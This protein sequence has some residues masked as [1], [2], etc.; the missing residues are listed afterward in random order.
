MMRPHGILD[1]G[2]SIVGIVHSDIP[3]AVAR[4][5][6]SC[7][8]RRGGWIGAGKVDGVRMSRGVD[9]RKSGAMI[10][11]V[12]VAIGRR[13]GSRRRLLM[14]AL[15]VSRHLTS[16]VVSSRGPGRV[17]IL[18]PRRIHG[19]EKGVQCNTTGDLDEKAATATA[20]V[21]ARTTAMAAVRCAEP[22]VVPTSMNKSTYGEAAEE[23]RYERIGVVAA[24]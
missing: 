22:P 9:L 21:T 2:V 13:H 24:S 17:G 19:G 12:V 4:R 7:H 23:R 8:G 15:I 1:A 6:T 3:V 20:T 16:S 14:L 10:L 18:L 11:A 5:R